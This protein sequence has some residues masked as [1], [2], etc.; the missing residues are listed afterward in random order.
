M[1]INV[2]SALTADMKEQHCHV[3]FFQAGLAVST[4]ILK[5]RDR[6]KHSAV[7]CNPAIT[8]V[9]GVIYVRPFNE[10]GFSRC[11]WELLG[12]A[13]TTD[14]YWDVDWAKNA[15]THTSEQR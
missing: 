12:N 11:G 3:G 9:A 1:E 7:P 10:D 2:S 13:K 6:K 4:F 5:K 14:R 15:N 8:M